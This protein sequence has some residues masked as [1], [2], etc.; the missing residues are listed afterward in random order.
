MQSQEAAFFAVVTNHIFISL[1]Q[2]AALSQIRQT[3][4]ENLGEPPGQFVNS[5]KLVRPV[6]VVFRVC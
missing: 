5:H 4:H 6:T 1:Q 3:H 2:S